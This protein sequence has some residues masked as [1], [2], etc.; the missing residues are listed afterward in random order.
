MHWYADSLDRKRST[1]ETRK[2]NEVFNP[3]PARL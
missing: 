3:P 2:F 1:A